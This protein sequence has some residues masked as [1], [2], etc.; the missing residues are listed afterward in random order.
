MD[1][2]KGPGAD[3][4][5]YL[6]SFESSNRKRKILVIVIGIVVALVAAGAFYATI[7]SMGSMSEDVN[8]AFGDGKT[9][10]EGTPDSASP[11]NSSATPDNN[12]PVP[13]T[14]N[15]P[16]STPEAQDKTPPAP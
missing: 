4:D 6:A 1:E 2:N 8:G 7:G 11:A 16:A 12:E 15:N 3:D 5:A 9:P 13:A 14:Q 10:A